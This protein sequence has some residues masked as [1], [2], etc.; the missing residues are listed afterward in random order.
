M[1]NMDT[2][3]TRFISVAVI[4][5]LGSSA[6]VEGQADSTGIPSI[7][8]GGFASTCTN[9]AITDTVFLIAK[10]KNGAGAMVP[11]KLDLDQCVGLTPQGAST[12]PTSVSMWP[13]YASM[14]QLMFLSGSSSV[15][16]FCA[17]PRGYGYF[18]IDISESMSANSNIDFADDCRCPDTCVGNTNGK[19]VC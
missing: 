7:A 15:A 4:I 17:G 9:V 3:F 6:A 12:A 2:S 10:C 5:V 16:C 1:S 18:T 19:L 13:Y 8:S 11:S 14:Q